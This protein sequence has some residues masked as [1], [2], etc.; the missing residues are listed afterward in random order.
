M[1]NELL[2][3]ANDIRRGEEIKPADAFKLAKEL[4]REQCFDAAQRLAAY[5]LDTDHVDAADAVELRQKLALWTSKNPDAPDDTK[6]DQALAI[7]DDIKHTEGGQSLENSTDSES[8]GIAGGICKRKW[9]VTGRQAVLEQSL[10]FYELGAEQGIE[11]D[12]GYTATNAAFVIDLLADVDSAAGTA[13]KA[14]AQVIRQ[15]VLDTLL[16]IKGDPAWPG[17][18]PREQIRW[19]NET[20]AEAYFG[21]GDYVNA[22]DYLQQA[23]GGE[24]VEPWE[25]ETSARQFAWLARRQDPDAKTNADFDQSPA[26]MVLREV[27]GGDA[28]AVSLFAG[29]FGLALSGGGFR[30]SLVS[31]GRRPER[32][33]LVRNLDS[34]IDF[35][36]SVP[37]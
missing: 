30:A 36:S 5:L 7:L 6:H 22:T 29:K 19:F 12:N 32:R 11:Q 25:L 24:A 27:F 2:Q 37:V 9:L 13:R 20:I 14:E 23:Y 16:P 3:Q 35:R 10:R 31:G 4:A 28:P 33:R 34:H 26:W 18:P 21:L 15:Q 8:L 17:G 1:N